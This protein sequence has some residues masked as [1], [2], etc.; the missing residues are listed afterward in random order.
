M[1][2][3]LCPMRHDTPAG[4]SIP[5]HSVYSSLLSIE[6]VVNGRIMG[7]QSPTD[8]ERN[9]HLLPR[10][11]ALK[12]HSYHQTAFITRSSRP[13]PRQ[14]RLVPINTETAPLSVT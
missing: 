12:K 14:R 2:T 13:S 5:T 7:Y 4:C 10:G 11:S 1:Y 6:R 3:V 8:C 9:A